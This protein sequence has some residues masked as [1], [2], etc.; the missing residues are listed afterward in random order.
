M[1][2]NKL[3]TNNYNATPSFSGTAALGKKILSVPTLK[4]F[5]DGL[6]YNNFQMPV[7]AM[8]GILY[9]ATIVPRFIQAT[10]KHDRREILIRD[11]TSITAILF[12]A[13]ALNRVISKGLSKHS[14]FALLNKPKNHN[15][16]GFMKKL[17]QYLIPNDTD[18][19]VNVLS[20]GDLTLK[21]SNLDRYKDGI[22]NFF[23]FIDEQGGN[24]GKV[25][26]ADKTVK[27]NAE[28]IVG[29]DILKATKE[30]I[31]KAFE[32]AKGSKELENIYN[33]FKNPKNSYIDKAKK[34]NSTSNFIATILLTPILMISVEKFN[35]YNTKRI[36]AKEK[37]KK[38]SMENAKA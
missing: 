28:K 14:G 26:S 18:K 1:Q 27:E 5:A 13:K 22:Q 2:V 6:E 37:A 32:K 33:V 19:S 35:E 34:M 8:M 24:V 3:Q 29:K 36:L 21:Y 38:Q 30:E 20:S 25:L 9:G 15:E 17:S 4:K 31:G 10:D 7:A 11:F 16:S 23:K 12:F